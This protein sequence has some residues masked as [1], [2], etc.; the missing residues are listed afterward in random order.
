MSRRKNKPAPQP[1]PGADAPHPPRRGR[2]IVLAAAAL[3]L[4]LGALLVPQ[5]IAAGRDADGDAPA[6][7]T[8]PGP[9]PDGMAWVP[10]GAFWMGDAGFSDAPVHRVE[11]DGFWMDKTEVTNGQF[12][13]FVAA[14]G[15]VTVAERA[16]DWEEM[17]K[18]LPPG[19]PRPPDDVLVA[20][21]LVFTPPPGRVPLEE[22][23]RWWR[24][25]PGADWRHPDGPG[26]TIEGKDN[27]P[28]VHVCHDDAVAYAKWAG[29][30]LPTEAEW[31]FAARGGLDRKPYAWGDEQK[32][33]GRWMANIWQGRFPGENT[34]EDGFPLAAPVA[35]FPPNAF[36]LH[37][38]AGNV[39]EWC[40]DWYRN[41]YYAAS[42]PRNP[43]GPPDSFDPAEPGIP[44]RVQRGGSFLCSDLYCV[45]YKPGTRG[46]G[47]VTSGLSHVGFR[48][49]KSP[50][51]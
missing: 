46:K 30:R 48:C 2:R 24:Y 31:E 13:R 11:V 27:L 37:D 4:L 45:R 47:E 22:H 15:Y 6:H 14:T 49:V 41:D 16:P 50:G 44:K 8:P 42:P 28:V 38:M 33:G 36:G 26:S 1:A 40:A 12:A 10:G 17:K 25:V 5:F 34:A 21:S 23:Y 39:W 43:Q 19:T 20:G 3:A 51:R 7:T 9:A 18:Q 32:S 29:K 35:S